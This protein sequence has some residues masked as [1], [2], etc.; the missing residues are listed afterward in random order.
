MTRTEYHK[1]WRNKNREKFTIYQREYQR[2]YR[3]TNPQ[4]SRLSVK[5]YIKKN[6]EYR[7]WWDM[8]GRCYNPKR[9][10]YKY[11]GGRGIKVLYRSYREFLRDVGKRPSNKY[12]IDRI[13]PLG[14]YTIGNCRWADSHTQR[15]NQVRNRL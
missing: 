8:R 9:D 2:R 14:H 13:N 7:V 5:T 15:M 3:K 1:S 4:V 12:S 11:Y 6:P 10:S